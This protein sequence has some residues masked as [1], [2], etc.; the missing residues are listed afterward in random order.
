MGKLSRENYEAWCFGHVSFLERVLVGSLGKLNRIVRLIGFCAHDCHMIPRH[1]EYKK[2]R[3][4][5]KH[6]LRFS[7]SGRRKLEDAYARHFVWNKS[8]AQKL[9]AIAAMRLISNPQRAKRGVRSLAECT[10]EIIRILKTR[11]PGTNDNWRTLVESSD[12][13]VMDGRAAGR[14]EETIDAYIS[15]LK[16]SCKRRL[17]RE[18]EVGQI[19]TERGSGDDPLCFEISEIDR[20]LAM[21]LLEMVTGEVMDE[22]RGDRMPAPGVKFSTQL[23][24]SSCIKPE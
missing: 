7:K 23:P 9:L 21:E 5:Q 3:K 6:R 2:R 19:E 20:D 1:T 17:W 16:E 22:A 18:T 13:D 10:D 8:A 24:K 11:L 15:T 4:G 12:G 14:I